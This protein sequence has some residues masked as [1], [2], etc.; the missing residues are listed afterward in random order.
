MVQNGTVLFEREI[1]GKQRL[2][3]NESIL[4]W[5]LTAGSHSAYFH[6]SQFALGYESTD[7]QLPHDLVGIGNK[8]DPGVVKFLALQ[9]EEGTTDL[10]IKPGYTLHRAHQYHHDK[11]NGNS[12]NPAA[13]ETDLLNGGLDTNCSILENRPYNVSKHGLVNGYDDVMK[14]FLKS[15]PPLHK[16]KYVE[17]VLEDMRKLKIPDFNL[18]TLD[19]LLTETR[20]GQL[21][22]MS[23]DI[24]KKIVQKTQAAVELVSDRGY[25]KSWARH[26]LATAYERASF[27]G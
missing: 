12:I 27:L 13:S 4:K 11:W 18:I 17:R 14:V 22:K 23:A 1:E 5:I 8:Y 7:P 24:C 20:L 10:D 26:D 3:T 9:F 6:G 15:N 25:E 2:P 16:I 21:F 19:D